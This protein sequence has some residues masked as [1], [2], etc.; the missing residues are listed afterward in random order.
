MIEISVYADERKR[1]RN[2]WDYLGIV[3]VPSRHIDSLH[4]D[5]QAERNLNTFPNEVKFGYLN[6]SAGGSRAETSKGWL[7]ILMDDA[8]C[9][10]RR[11]YFSILGIDN[12]NIDYH[13][14]GPGG[15]A[16][17][18]YANVYSRFFRASLLGLVNFCFKGIDVQIANVYH[19]TEGNL[20]NHQYFDWHAIRE[21]SRREA[22]INFLNDRVVFVHSDPR[23]ESHYPIASE[24]LQLTDLILGTMTHAI[25][26]ENND[27]KGKLECVKLVLPFVKDLLYKPY[28]SNGS[29]DQ[30]NRF[31]ISHFPLHRQHVLNDTYL[32]EEYYKPQLACI[33]QIAFGQGCLDL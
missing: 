9:R 19:D 30:L 22:R 4:S 26:I 32:P 7:R 10:K 14:F 5:L 1:I 28:V 11:L 8:Q 16:S 12:D 25:H 21:I 20:E 13:L 31:S 17:G 29:F 15:T 2:R 24:M 18:K 6:K 23:K 27:N 3:A 33:D